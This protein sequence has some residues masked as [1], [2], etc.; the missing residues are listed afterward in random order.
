MQ[1]SLHA[2]TIVQSG[3][4]IQLD[5][6]E[7]AEGVQVDVVVTPSR[8]PEDSDGGLGIADFLRSLPPNQLRQEEWS[9]RDKE[10]AKDRAEWDR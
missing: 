1:N 9:R 4:R 2:K 7:L 5:I 3:G 8:H 10:F 6:P